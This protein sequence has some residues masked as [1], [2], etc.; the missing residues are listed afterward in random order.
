LSSH[1]G[2]L[3]LH[4]SS[5]VSNW[6]SVSS[7]GHNWSWSLVRFELHHDVGGW[8]SNWH[9]SHLGWLSENGWLAD[10]SSLEWGNWLSQNLWLGNWLSNNWSSSQWLSLSLTHGIILWVLR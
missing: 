5:V 6:N 4:K 9:L 3:L 2:V 8:S 7:L 1:W 10:W